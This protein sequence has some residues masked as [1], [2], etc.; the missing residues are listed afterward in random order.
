MSKQ[1]LESVWSIAS[2][3]RLVADK[4]EI[5][6]TLGLYE[7]LNEIGHG[8]FSQ[9]YEAIDT[10]N[11]NHVAVKV[12]NSEVGGDGFVREVGLGMEL[13]HPNLLSALDLGYAVDKKR[14]VVYQLANGGS[15]RRKIKKRWCQPCF[16]QQLHHPNCSWFECFTRQIRRP[17]R[18]QTRKYV[19]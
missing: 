2:L 11:G 14:Y 6:G 18:H 12:F 7:L 3:A 10:R 19:V 13:S 5:S 16:N 15:L 1:S 17:P 8:S 9:V 4:E